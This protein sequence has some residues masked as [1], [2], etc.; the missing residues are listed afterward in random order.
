MK[1]LQ[2]TLRPNLVVL[3]VLSLLTGLLLSACGD[4]NGSTSNQSQIKP[5][6][7]GVL[8]PLTGPNSTSGMQSR[9]GVELANSENSKNPSNRKLEL[10]FEDV[11][12]TK[13][14]A[15]NGY[16]RLMSKG[17]LDGLI[18]GGNSVQAS[19]LSPLIKADRIPS[20]VTVA[21]NP[22]LSQNGNDSLFFSRTLDDTSAA[23]TTQYVVNQLKKKKV[24]LVHSND[25][26]GFA[27]SVVYLQELQKLN[28]SPVANISTSLTSTD[29]SAA[30]KELRDSEADVILGWHYTAPAQALIKQVRDAG[31]TMPIVGSNVAFGLSATIASLT[32]QQGQEVYA[33]MDG[34]PIASK[35]TAIQEFVKH[36][37]ESEN[38][39]QPDGLGLVG[40]DTLNIFNWAANQGPTDSASLHKVLT[41]LKNFKGLKGTY[42]YDPAANGRLINSA[43]LISLNSGKPFIVQEI[44]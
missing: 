32:P 29:F 16:K 7:I 35:D 39:L 34:L 13:E 31:L 2:P 40:Y 18:N 33:V 41:T 11:G 14:D 38:S 12:A 4:A 23:A 9:R 26:V 17:K 25:D 28:L 24:A 6:R 15:V 20:L 10:T 36:F 37:Q 3:T 30:I 44:K 8:V 21:S 5:L 43:V 1:N 27:M 22:Q 42:S 19:S